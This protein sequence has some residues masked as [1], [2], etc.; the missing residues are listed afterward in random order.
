MY[1][2]SGGELMIE[3][4]YDKTGVGKRME[5]L[6]SKAKSTREKVSED[7]DISKDSL[8]AYEKGKSIMSAEVMAKV[9]ILYN[10][11]MEYLLTGCE[12]KYNV[13]IPEIMISL[14]NITLSNRNIC[15]QHLIT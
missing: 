4:E 9:C 15:M 11:S 7:I 3:F 10:T 12:P 1:G 8:Y 14:G 13:I 6:R 2:C 5:L